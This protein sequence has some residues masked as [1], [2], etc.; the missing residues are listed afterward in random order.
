MNEQTV[1]EK[2]RNSLRA[3]IGSDGETL[4]KLA[5]CNQYIV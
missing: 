1:G 4:Y 2:K 5:G 3:L